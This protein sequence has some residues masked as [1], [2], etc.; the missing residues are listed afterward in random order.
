MITDIPGSS[1]VYRQGYIAYDN[2]AKRTM[3]AVPDEILE[4]H[5]AVS[6]ACVRAMA[7]GARQA[8]GCDLAVAV[9][10]IAGP[11]GG[12]P[13]K[14]VGTAWISVAYNTNI[15]THKIAFDR[16]RLNNKRFTAHAALHLAYRTILNNKG[17]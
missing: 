8:S 1:A 13:D 16:G 7:Q 4:Q 10:G 2:N 11:D 14:P 17:T 12:T 3:L 9:S 5:G 15:V 6:E